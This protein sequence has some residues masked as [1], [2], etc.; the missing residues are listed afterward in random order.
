M[1]TSKYQKIKV[2][3]KRKLARYVGVW[4]SQIP[5]SEVDNEVKAI[6]NIYEKNS[7]HPDK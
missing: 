7:R 5:D 3:I 2:I 4:A 1:R 6:M